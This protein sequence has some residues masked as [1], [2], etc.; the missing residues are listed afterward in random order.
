MKVLGPTLSYSYAYMRHLL[1]RDLFTVVQP[2]VLYGERTL[3]R[4]E[5]LLV[6]LRCA[7]C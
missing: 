3:L 2:L 4:T 7:A 1:W 5:S 6:L